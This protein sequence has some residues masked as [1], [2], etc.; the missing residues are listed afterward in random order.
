MFSSLIVKFVCFAFISSFCPWDALALYWFSL[1][2]QR[3]SFLSF[4]FLDLVPSAL[5]SQS[6][7]LSFWHYL[8]F[9]WTEANLLAYTY[10]SLNCLEI[11]DFCVIR[12]KVVLQAFVWVFWLIKSYH[13]GKDRIARSWSCFYFQFTHRLPKDFNVFF[14]S[15]NSLSSCE[16]LF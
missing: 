4:N 6:L 3:Y 7:L 2:M 8:V 5:T 12:A 1:P 14:N 15:G 13:F 9:A 11:S 10:C 16:V